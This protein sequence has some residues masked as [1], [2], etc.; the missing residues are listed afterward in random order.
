VGEVSWR[1]FTLAEAEVR[2]RSHGRGGAGQARPSR[3]PGVLT[4][5]DAVPAAALPPA[6]I[7]GP[8]ASRAASRRVRAEQA[9]LEQRWSLP[10]FPTLQFGWQLSATAARSGPILPPAGPSPSSIATSARIEAN[11]ASDHG[12]PPIATRVSGDQRRSGRL[13]SSPPRASQPRGRGRDQDRHGDSR[14]SRGRGLLTDL[15][16]SLRAAMGTPERDRPAATSAGSTPRAGSAL[17]RAS[18]EE[19]SMDR[20]AVVLLL[21]RPQALRV[22]GPL[23]PRAPRPRAGQSRRGERYEVFAETDC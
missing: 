11:A 18:S 14:V 12:S 4:S 8:A 1:R 16:D 13:P 3:R 20:R 5:P 17:G 2:R 15:L 23:R 22:A 21:L 7:D 6:G 9:E 19:V 10:T